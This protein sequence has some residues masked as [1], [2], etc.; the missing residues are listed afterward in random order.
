MTADGLRAVPPEIATALQRAVDDGFDE[1]V[2]CLADYVRLPSLRGQEAPAQD[3]M[4][5]AL[6]RRGLDVDHWRIKAEELAHLP[7][8]SPLDV[9][10]A[11]AYTVVASHRPARV[12]GRS[13]ILQGHCDVVPEGPHDMWTHPPFEPVIEGGWM[14]GRGAGDMKAGIVAGL[15][16]LDA[17]RRAGYEPA[18]TVH[19]QTVIEEESTG[20]GALSTLQ[21][22]YRADAALIPEPSGC[23]LTRASV[24]VLWFKLKVRGHPTHVAYAEQGHN[25]IEA[26]YDLMKALR[27]LEAR[28]NQAVGDDAHFHDHPHP[29]NFNPGKIVG[30]D[31]PSSVPAW[32]EVECRIGIL[33]GTKL[34]DAQREIEQTVRDAARS[35]PFLANQPPELT[36]NGFLAE[37]YVLPPNTPAEQALRAAQS[38]DGGGALGERAST[39]TCDARFYGLYHDI[40]ALV[41]GPRADS[42]HGYDERVD[43]ESMRQVTRVIGLFIAGWCGLNKI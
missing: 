1:Q 27:G 40:P 6:R 35:H 23:R 26:A 28:W 22:G 5:A 36:W 43:L 21:R 32:C 39:G 9:D 12:A 20:N 25:A 41:Y 13:L 3:F 7:G 34:A 31:W 15:Y 17:I 2:Q 19:F 10:F 24:G 14:H 37:G 11:R 18:A 33:P 42:I 38:L 8:F 29:L 16:A 4:A 30:G